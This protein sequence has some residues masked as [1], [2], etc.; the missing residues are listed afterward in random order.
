VRY[1][2]H[3][4]MTSSLHY[5]VAGGHVV[6]AGSLLLTRPRWVTAA[7]SLLDTQTIILH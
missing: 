3:I 4:T 1:S 7:V 2:A 6:S 5:L